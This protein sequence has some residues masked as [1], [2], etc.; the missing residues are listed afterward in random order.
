MATFTVKKDGSGTHTTIQ[1]AI[2]S[3]SSGDTINIEGAVFDENVDLYKDGISFVG[4]GR[5]LTE[6]RGVQETQISKTCTYALGSNSISCPA[7][8]AGLLIGRIV[9]GTGIPANTRIS[10]IEPTSFKI[11][12]NTTAARTNSA[13]VMPIVDAAFRWRGSGNSLTK[14]KV[15]ALQGRASKSLDSGAVFFRASGLGAVAAANYM[16]DDCEITARGDSAIMCDNTGPGGGT[17]QNCIINGQTYVGALPAQVHAFSNLAISCNILTATTVE[18]PSDNLVDVVIGSPI[19]AVTGLVPASTTVSSISGNVLT[20]NKSLLSG[21][22]TTQSLTFT[23]IQFNVPNVARQLVVFQPNNTAP[24][25]FLN[26]T[27]AGSCGGGI[28]YNTAITVDTAGSVVQGNTITAD[29]GSDSAPLIGYA[30]RVRGT[31][32]TTENNFYQPSQGKTG[33]GFYVWT[34]T[35]FQYGFVVGT[36]TSDVEYLVTLDQVASGDPVLVYFNK[37]ML[38]LI[39]MSDPYFSQESNWKLVGC[40]LKHDSSA[41][42]L[43]SGFKNFEQVRQMELRVGMEPG[44]K[45]LIHK[46]IISDSSRQLRTV[47]RSEIENHTAID[48]VLK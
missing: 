27:I 6:I 18:I 24:V 21:V 37:A 36:N 25:Y 32:S 39:V 41:K 16:V 13:V 47:K 34:P 4:A 10:S 9:T 23:N 35:G 30:L 17:V 15:T 45:Y 29:V 22:G 12:S 20:L 38:K 14:V 42:R 33:L 31:S 3:A 40:I 2:Y 26:N 1:S 7:G 28:C 46:M 5:T 43:T 8:T 19:L 11:S 44:Q 48:I